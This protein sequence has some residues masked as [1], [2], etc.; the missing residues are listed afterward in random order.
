MLKFLVFYTCKKTPDV[1]VIRAV[2]ATDSLH[3]VTVA[4]AEERAVVGF[5][6]PDCELA[7]VR[8]V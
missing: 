3:A 2:E 8:L 1:P 6:C 7:T 5:N 4:R